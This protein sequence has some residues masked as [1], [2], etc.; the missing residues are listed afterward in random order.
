VHFSKARQATK[1]PGSRKKTE[2][3]ILI[4]SQSIAVHVVAGGK[5]IVPIRAGYRII[6]PASS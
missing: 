3:E 5:L 4:R 1:K 6:L 2:E